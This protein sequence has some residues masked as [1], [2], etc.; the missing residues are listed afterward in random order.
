M[1]IYYIVRYKDFKNQIFLA[2]LNKNMWRLCTDRNKA[3]RF[4]FPYLA[5]LCIAK[6]CGANNFR[7]GDFKIV[8]V[9]EE[10]WVPLG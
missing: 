8:K 3:E 6:Y 9:S 4:D 10:T 1:S 5:G 7:K 2:P